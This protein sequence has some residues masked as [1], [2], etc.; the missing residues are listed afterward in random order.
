M[1]TEF[2]RRPRTWDT[3]GIAR[4]MVWIGPISSVFDIT[5]FLLLWFVFRAN[6]P[7]G[8]ATFQS[9]W[10]IESLLSQTLIIHM[11]RTE[12]IPFIQSRAA[13]PV[14]LLTSLIMAIGLYLPYSTLG[15]AVSL[16]RL[17]AAFF[18]WLVVT[19]LTYGA[20]TQL[21]K[22]WYIRRFHAWL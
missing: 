5:T 9:G 13:V 18:P 21:V 19:L 22:T 4:F 1:D 12:R 7:A 14:L 2:L 11:I 16:V 3:T 10:F 6:G 17:P 15:S 20:L 8:E